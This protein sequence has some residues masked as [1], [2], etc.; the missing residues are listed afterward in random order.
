MR[1]THRT[2]NNAARHRGWEITVDPGTVTTRAELRAA[3]RRLHERR[4]LSYHDLA[5]DSQVSSATLH[6]TVNGTSFPQWK[7]LREILLA[8]GIAAD[9]L[10]PW[11]RA[12]A[13]AAAGQ[14]AT[15]R[16]T[17]TGSGADR[18]LGQPLEEVADPFVLE[19]HRPITVGSRSA[20]PPLPRYVPRDHDRKL[21]EVV[22]RARGGV[23]AM[24]ILVAGSSTG[25]TRALFE[26]LAPLRE[27][28]GW[29]LWHPSSPTRRE[30][31]TELG[32][33]R[34]R[35]VVWLNE[36]Q[37]Y[38]GATAGGDEHA[39]VA[40]RDLLA[41]S[42]RAPVLIVGTLWPTHLANL[43]AVAG[44]QARSL[45]EGSVI[46]VPDSFTGADL[47][48]VRTAAQGDP[49]LTMALR[50]VDDGR[51]GQY[52]AG[53][54]ELVRRYELELTSAARAIVQVA[55]D[56]RRLGYRSSL[57]HA[58]LE[59]AAHAYMS[60]QDWDALGD[61]WFERALTETSRD[62]RGARGP[63]TRI[64]PARPSPAPVH[65]STRTSSAAAA[66]STS[67]P[68]TS[69]S[70]A[71]PLAPRTSPRSRSGKPAPPTPTRTTWRHSGEPPG[72]GA[73]TATPPNCGRTPP[74]TA[75]STP[76]QNCS[77]QS[78]PCTLT[79]SDQQSGPSPKS[80]SKTRSA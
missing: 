9:A 65:L 70:T 62:C 26:A 50:R 24:A 10:E 56:A 36:T 18:A 52:L 4:G 30:A 22:Q 27:A 53:G 42:A 63:L 7:T 76:P 54:P 73:C 21:A 12:H 75:T 45:V 71:A 46:K 39:A 28:G 1:R 77:A 80:P 57:P 13:R 19:V 2:P 69:S 49:R 44:S 23:S 3:L 61:D 43:C 6:D 38:L 20:L 74:T 67:S 47:E 14:A 59:T 17:R 8:Y 66:R 15:R 32:R 55:M 16:R 58:F 78:E 33:L 29:R 40:L 60:D 37:E 11:Q 34:P 41:D 64:R 25:K 72:T 79:N 5:A 48:A 31:L 35:T 51:I 68:T